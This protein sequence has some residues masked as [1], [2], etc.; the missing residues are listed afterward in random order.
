MRLPCE[1]WAR[2]SVELSLEHF[3]AQIAQ[4]P[5]VRT[6][7]RQVDRPLA[8]QG[9]RVEVRAQAI[10][11]D[12]VRVIPS[13]RAARAMLYCCSLTSIIADR[14]TVAYARLR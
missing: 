12:R 1:R 6:D 8:V 5:L 9:V 10:G 13:S 14:F 4:R 11:R 3:G 2:V 7:V